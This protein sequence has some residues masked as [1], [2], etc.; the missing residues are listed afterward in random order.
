MMYELFSVLAPVLVVAAIGFGWAK[1]GQPFDNNFVST[2]NFNIATPLLIFSSLTKLHVD[3]SAMGEM[4]LATFTTSM[5]VAA[6]GVIVLKALRIPLR[7]Y[8]T[9]VM[10]PNTGNVGLPVC[11]L[12]FGEKGLAFA[13]VVH[14]VS[15]AIQFTLGVAITAG[16]FSLRDLAKVPLLY[17]VA[18]AY[19]VMA[20][21]VTLPPWIANAAALVGQLAIPLMLVAL[22]ASL[23][24]FRTGQ[25]GRSLILTAAR[26]G[27][28]FG[29]AWGVVW[30]FGLDH[31][32]TGVLVSQM[33][34]PAAVFTYM[35]AARYDTDPEGVAG[36]VFV[37]T[38]LGFAAMPLV[39]W[40]VL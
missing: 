39:L 19:V 34:G 25:L 20:T 2:F 6:L 36:V 27:L 33:S 29:A 24:R 32:Q 9:P 16:T 21:G 26:L 15:A 14:V 10:I 18:A 37:S 17:A 35:L 30:L 23:V 38:I 7:P 28:G 8:L 40:M 5:S 4:A 1:N 3:P 11:L 22:G 13:V 31:V 12:A